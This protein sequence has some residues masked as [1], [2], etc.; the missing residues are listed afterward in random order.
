MKN[1]S[2]KERLLQMFVIL[3]CLIILA[4]RFSSTCSN[5]QTQCLPDK[6]PLE[7]TA[8]P[9]FHTWGQNKN[10]SIVI[11][12]RS[13]T[14]TTSTAEFEAI[15]GGVKE[16][17]NFKVSNCSNITFENATRAGRPW[18]GTDYPPYD[19]VWIV[20]TTMRISS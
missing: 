20:R 15:D 16:W 1:I 8:N 19:T 14:E 3:T 17:N 12:D 2:D 7:D 6:P 4:F 13:T 10:I 5:A 18:N 9:K 11:Y